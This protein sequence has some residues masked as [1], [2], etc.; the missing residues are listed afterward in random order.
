MLCPEC[1]EIVQGRHVCDPSPEVTAD[2]PFVATHQVQHDGRAPDDSHSPQQPVR[3]AWFQLGELLR[4]P[5]DV[6]R[7]AATG[8]YTLELLREGARVAVLRDA[9][10]VGRGLLREPREHER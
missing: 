5:D 7:V 10:F 4:G 1:F 3:G 9:D 8:S 6:V 2:L